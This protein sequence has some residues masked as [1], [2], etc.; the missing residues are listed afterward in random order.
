MENES[1]ENLELEKNEEEVSEES[2][3]KLTLEQIQGIKRRQFT[4]LAKEL[5]VELSKPEPEKPKAP[6]PKE[7]G[8]DY[9]ELTYLEVKGVADE[10][11]D[12]ILEG[13]E[14]TDKSL[15]DFLKTEWVQKELKE[16][17]AARAVD[18]AIPGGTKRSQG[19]SQAEDTVEYYVASGKQPPKEKGLEFRKKV[20]EA[21]LKKEE[22][23][24][25][26]A[27]DSLITPF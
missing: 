6:E 1:N 22:D 20:L 11:H 24:D 26:F 3:P 18:N 16:K 14:H 7:K 9:G 27:T 12:W 8:F 4:K 17:A 15:K 5:G 23:G 19:G 13:M 10:D 2:K 25:K 21:R